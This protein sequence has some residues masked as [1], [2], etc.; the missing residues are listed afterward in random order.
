F[1]YR[2][3]HSQADSQKRNP[4]FPCILYSPHLAF[5]SAFPK[6]GSHKNSVQALHGLIHFIPIY[7]FRM[8][9]THIYTDFVDRS[10]MDKGF[11]NGFIG[12]LKL[13]ILS[14]KSDGDFML[15]V[16]V[17]FQKLP[18]LGKIWLGGVR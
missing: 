4:V 13:Y 11:Q 15:G 16:L 10:R 8:Y 12:I 5:Y 17:L 2:H 3:L 9:G 1:D 18:P 6:A 7:M 14:Y